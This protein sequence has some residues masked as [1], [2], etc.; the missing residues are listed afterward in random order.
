MGGMGVGGAGGVSGSTSSAGGAPLVEDCFNDTDDDN[1]GSPDCADPDCMDQYSCVPEA[2]VP[3][4]IREDM[5]CQAPF[6]DL[7][8]HDCSKCACAGVSGSCTATGAFYN[9]SNCTGQT[10]SNFMV[11]SQGCAEPYANNGSNDLYAMVSVTAMDNGTCTSSEANTPHSVCQLHPNSVCTANGQACAPVHEGVT[12]VMVDGITCPPGYPLSRP[13]QP[14]PDT[15]GCSCMKTEECPSAIRTHSAATCL[16]N[17]IVVPL[18]GCTNT[19]QSVITSVRAPA[20]MVTCTPTSVPPSGPRT[21][22]CNR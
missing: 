13:V 9:M 5:S 6:V 2:S 11:T 1:D 7:D 17:V 12:C 18:N 22:C 19:N 15:C 8:L 3:R 10:G 14:Q 16:V 4:F 21:L 20:S